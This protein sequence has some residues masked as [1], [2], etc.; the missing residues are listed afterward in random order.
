M[1]TLSTYKLRLEAKKILKE[2]NF[3]VSKTALTISL[4]ASHIREYSNYIQSILGESK[5]TNY[6]ISILITELLEYFVENQP[7][8]VIDLTTI[9]QEPKDT[10]TLSLPSNLATEFKKNYVRLIKLAKDKKNNGKV[11]KPT[12]YPFL[13]ALFNHYKNQ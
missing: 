10:V 6:G 12:A 2:N 13:W 1:T 4:P 8:L 5:K 7:K 3:K 11:T 9:N